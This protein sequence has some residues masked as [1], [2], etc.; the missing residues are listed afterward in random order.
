MLSFI[1]LFFCSN[2]NADVF[3]IAHVGTNI[4]ATD[5]KDIFLGETQLVGSVKLVP[6]D[7]QAAQTEFLQK[8]IG[9]ELN[10]YNSTW[11]KKSFRDGLNP[12]AV[13]SSDPE[14]IEFVKRTD[15]AVGYT[16]IKPE[17]VTIVTTF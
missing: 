13:K 12:P 3:V 1:E 14:V 15:G 16:T 2:A 7:N 6:V 4:S 17:G 8:A 5:I 9:M 10:K 11:T